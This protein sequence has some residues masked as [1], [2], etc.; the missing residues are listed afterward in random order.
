MEAL[1]SLFLRNFYFSHNTIHGDIPKVPK[2]IFQENKGA[3]LTLKMLGRKI[4]KR[5][6]TRDKNC[7]GKFKF[8]ENYFL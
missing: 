4:A 7:R 6:E 8:K 3:Y 1:N 5:I 2:P